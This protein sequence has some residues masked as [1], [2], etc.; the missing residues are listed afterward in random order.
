[1]CD[2]YIWL[3]LG[4][5]GLTFISVLGF[6]FLVLLFFFAVRFSVVLIMTFSAV[7]ERGGGVGEG[8]GAGRGRR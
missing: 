6:L 3:H 4:L 5:Y 8:G 2:V 7:D 1:M